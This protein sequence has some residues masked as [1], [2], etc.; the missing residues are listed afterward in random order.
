[1]KKALHNIDFRQ[2]ELI[3]KQMSELSPLFV[4]HCLDVIK[5]SVKFHEYKLKI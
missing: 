1:M 5:A 3:K 2:R 4:T